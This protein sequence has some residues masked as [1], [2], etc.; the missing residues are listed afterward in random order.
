MFEQLSLTRSKL[1]GSNTTATPPYNCFSLTGKELEGC[2]YE[3]PFG[4]EPAQ[5]LPGLHVTSTAGTGLVHTAPAH[6]QDDYQVGIKQGLSLDCQVGE[7]GCYSSELGHGLAG[8]SVLSKDTVQHVLKL[9]GEKALHSEAY[10]HSYP[11][12][13]R[14]KQPVILRGSKQWFVRTDKLREKAL[15]AVQTVKIQP[16]N[17][18]QGFKGTIESRPYWCISRQR[19]W[20]TFIPVIYTW[21]RSCCV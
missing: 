19:A 20:G 16:E 1:P 5:L 2:G 3:T 4:G 14:T 17:A 13:W 10:I 7:D 6:G 9:L 12:D 21:W 8:L 11:Y 18:V 15:E